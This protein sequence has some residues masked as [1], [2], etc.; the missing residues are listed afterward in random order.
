VR[1]ARSSNDNTVTILHG[2]FPFQESLMLL[3]ATKMGED[4]NK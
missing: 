4:D 3:R 2:F 1:G